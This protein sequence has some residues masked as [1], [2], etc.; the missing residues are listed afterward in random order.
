M[1]KRGGNQQLW[2]VGTLSETNFLAILESTGRFGI[3]RNRSIGESKYREIRSYGMFVESS[4]APDTMIEDQE[5]GTFYTILLLSILPGNVTESLIKGTLMHDIRNDRDVRLYYPAYLRNIGDFPAI[6][7]NSLGTSDFKMSVLGVPQQ[8]PGK[9]LSANNV[10]SLLVKYNDYL[11]GAD[12]ALQKKVDSVFGPSTGSTPPYAEN[13]RQIEIGKM[14]IRAT[15][16][17]FCDGVQPND[18]DQPHISAPFEVGWSKDVKRRIPEHK[19]NTGTTSIFG[20][21]NALTRL[22]LAQ[23]GFGFSSDP[24]SG[25]SFPIWADNRELAR[26]G[27]I[28]GS[29]LVSSYW[30][31]GGYNSTWAG[32]FVMP[33]GEDINWDAAEREALARLEYCKAPDTILLQAQRLS[34]KLH[35]FE[36]PIYT[37]QGLEDLKAQ[38][39]SRH[40]V[41][42][43]QRIRR[44]SA[45]ERLQ[46][47]YKEF[48]DAREARYERLMTAPGVSDNTKEMGKAFKEMED[49]MATLALVRGETHRLTLPDH[50]RRP[51]KVPLISPL[52]DEEQ[53]R[54]DLGVEEAKEAEDRDWEQVLERRRQRKEN[55]K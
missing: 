47:K 35:I 13:Q 10:Q 21:N 26:V 53:A 54:V 27:E 1:Q 37:D 48:T 5:N 22:S 23:G 45:Q 50:L 30:F 51:S 6:Y 4:T 49:K 20:F 44:T 15:R 32:T 29:S 3:S 42:E 17:R 39:H 14:W 36:T 41:L 24:F 46:G 25:V 2:T 11:T 55:N 8:A 31:H 28:L 43:Q 9:W 40:T 18:E 7:F 38:L 16:A 34:N 12:P 52:T 33:S 19:K